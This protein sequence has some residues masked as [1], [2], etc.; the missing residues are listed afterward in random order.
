M[1]PADPL[2]MVARHSILEE[3]TSASDIV[4]TLRENRESRKWRQVK[5]LNFEGFP[6]KGHGEYSEN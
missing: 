5:H 1:I 4:S 3:K 6:R 2:I